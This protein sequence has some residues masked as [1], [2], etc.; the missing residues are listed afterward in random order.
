MTTLKRKKPILLGAALCTLWLVRFGPWGAIASG[1]LLLSA[2]LY[3]FATSERQGTPD[4]PPL[5][6]RGTGT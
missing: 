2:S 6:T 5:P 4:Q 1:I 3:V